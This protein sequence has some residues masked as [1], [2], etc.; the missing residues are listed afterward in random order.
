M[1]VSTNKN[2]NDLYLEDDESAGFD[3]TSG[4]CYS[5]KDKH[6]TVKIHLAHK[7]KSADVVGVLVQ[8]SSS[9]GSLSLYLNGQRVTD[10]LPLPDAVKDKAVYPV[11]M[12][13]GAPVQANFGP[14]I[15]RALSYKVRMLADAAK[16]DVEVS[17]R[18]NGSNGEA[19]VAVGFDTSVGGVVSKGG[20]WGGREVG[21][22]TAVVGADFGLRI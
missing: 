9:P 12:T 18:V 17:K 15:W 6:A 22:D 21:V 4:V 20:D 10:P 11:L 19:I 7:L 16:Q 2:V 3:V 14:S 8:R 5:G 1:G 13:K